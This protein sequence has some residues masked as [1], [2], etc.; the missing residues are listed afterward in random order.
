MHEALF[1]IIGLLIGSLCDV[2][3]MCVLQINRAGKE[4]SH[5]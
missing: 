1:F 3:V 5:E 2:V 4:P